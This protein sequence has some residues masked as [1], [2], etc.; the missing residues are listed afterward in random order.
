MSWKPQ[1]PR[2]NEDVTLTLVY[3][4]PLHIPWFAKVLS[5][6]DKFVPIET[7]VTLPFEGA[8]HADRNRSESGYQM[9]IPYYSP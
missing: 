5:T 8:R 7:K 4:M 9:G 1:N 2:E 3:R 6:N